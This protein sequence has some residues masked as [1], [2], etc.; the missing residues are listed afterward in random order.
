MKREVGWLKLVFLLIVLAALFY[1]ASQSALVRTWFANPEILRSF[2]LS[3]GILAPVILIL[4]QVFQTVI[5]ILPSEIT[6]IV[7]GFLF[8]P[9]LGILYNT[10][11]TFLGSFLVFLAGRKY[12]KKLVGDFFSKKEIV[13]F[14][15]F[16]R[17]RGLWALF[18]ARIAPFFPNDLISFAA[19]LTPVKTWQFNL[20]STLGFMVEIVLLTFFG[21]ELSQG[22]L[23]VPL[24]I[25][26]VFIILLLLVGLCKHWI[27][28]ILIKDLSLLEKEGKEAEKF[29][30][31]E[32]RKI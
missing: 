20:V 10:I 31:K 32:F 4:L 19:G 25:M 17:Q 13:H 28:K 3:S 22:K 30:E 12:G 26:G 24:L 15:L 7:G 27:H 8:G 2:L 1:A 14:N 16:F 6:T 11:G 23:S 5:S 9:V 21:S 18:L 29:I